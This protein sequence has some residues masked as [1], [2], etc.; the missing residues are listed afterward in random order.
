MKIVVTSSGTGLDA[1]VDPRFG[2]AGTLILFD[3][4]KGDFKAVD[5]ACNLNAAQ[6]AGIQAAR[7][8]CELGAECLITG[9]CGPKAYR[10][11]E[12]GGVRVFVN[13]GGTVG[14]AIEAFEA[15]RLPAADA[16]NVQGHWS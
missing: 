6:G 14:E 11:L 2:R 4:E 1:A 15:G 16:P 8:V 13:A 10:V 12:A 7:R 9:N 3:T 5:N